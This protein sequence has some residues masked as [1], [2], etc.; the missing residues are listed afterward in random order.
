MLPDLV[1]ESI[2]T[3]SVKVSK[4]LEEI[5]ESERKYCQTLNTIVEKLVTPCLNRRDLFTA[6]D[7]GLLFGNIVELRQLH[8][9]FYEDLLCSTHT[10]GQNTPYSIEQICKIIHRQLPPMAMAYNQY[11]ANFPAATE[12]YAEITRTNHHRRHERHATTTTTRDHAATRHVTPL[13][14]NTSRG[15]NGGI[16]SRVGS[17]RRKNS[18][19]TL[20][21]KEVKIHRRHSVDYRYLEKENHDRN[22]PLRSPFRSPSGVCRK[23]SHCSSLSPPSGQK[24]STTS[25]LLSRKSIFLELS[26]NR[27]GLSG[28]LSLLAYLL[29]P[30]QRVMRYPLLLKSLKR[31]LSMLENNNDQIELASSAEQSAEE[32]AMVTN[33]SQPRPSP[34]PMPKLAP[35]HVRPLISLGNVKKSTDKLK[36]E[37]KVKRR[38]SFEFMRQAVERVLRSR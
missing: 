8:K 38:R 10:P 26:L 5:I 33:I 17:F 22:S 18:T 27:S 31:H 16:T 20:L 36:N 32:L 37:E 19:L 9:T 6:D 35:S 4:I 7:I 30:V 23:P 3:N 28:G 14:S 15:I 34:T 1:M 11:C 12:F 13:T 21:N 29:E 25:S 24:V 2:N